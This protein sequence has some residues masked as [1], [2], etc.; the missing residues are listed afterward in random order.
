MAPHTRF[1]T[2]PRPGPNARLFLQDRRKPRRRATNP[3][4]FRRR[5]PQPRSRFP[6]GAKLEGQRHLIHIAGVSAGQRRL[7]ETSVDESLRENDLLTRMS[8]QMRS[9]L[10]ASEAGEGLAP[11]I[12]VADDMREK[13]VP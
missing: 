12:E 13:F 10:L 2:V 11:R 4:A 3:W 9:V 7:P 8:G 5:I 6:R 1:L